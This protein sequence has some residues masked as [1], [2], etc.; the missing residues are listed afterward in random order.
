MCGRFSLNVDPTEL[1]TLIPD[2]IVD[3]DV[4]K[5]YNIAPSQGVA[6]VLNESER[7]LS[8]IQ[9]GL[10]PHWAKDPKIGIKMINARGETIHE[11]PSFRSSFKSKR[12]LILADGFYEWKALPG[13]NAK[14]PVYFRLADTKPFAFAGIWDSWSGGNSEHPLRTCCIITTSANDLV[15]TAH[16]RMPV[17]L[18]SLNFDLWLQPGAVNIEELKGVLTQY[19]AEKMVMYPVS[20]KVNNVRNDASDLVL[21]LFGNE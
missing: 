11:K 7:R 10:I 6:A 9:W 15:S 13:R 2:L 3:Q 18:P 1:Q 21:P 17:I 19:P 20:T 8:Y 16:H 12:C 4:V 14:I 5:R